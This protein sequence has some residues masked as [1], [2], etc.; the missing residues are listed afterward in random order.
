MSEAVGG[1]VALPRWWADEQYCY[2]TTRGKCTGRAQQIEIW[3]GVHEGRVYMISGKGE[4]AD[5]VRNLR[6]APEVEIRVGDDRRAAKARVV[7]DGGDHPARRVIAAKYQGWREDR[8][9]FGWAA[10]APLVEVTRG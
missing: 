2:L 6:A 9:L 3:F 5:W 4:R 10:G 7:E 1:R 8:T